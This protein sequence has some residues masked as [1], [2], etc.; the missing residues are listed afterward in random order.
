MWRRRGLS[1]ASLGGGVE[2]AREGENP[3]IRIVERRR[4]GIRAAICSLFPFGFISFPHDR[5]A[6]QLITNMRKLACAYGEVQPQGQ[7]GAGV[8]TRDVS[9]SR[10]S[11]WRHARLAWQGERGMRR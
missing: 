10:A 3:R 9:E 7:A 1:R 2:S 6:T 4:I 11:V 8:L 5:P